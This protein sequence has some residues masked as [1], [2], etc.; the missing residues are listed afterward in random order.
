MS[1]VPRVHASSFITP[2][3]IIAA[4]NFHASIIHRTRVVILAQ[5]DS[6]IHSQTFPHHVQDKTRITPS[7]VHNKPEC[8]IVYS[9]TLYL[10]V[11]SLDAVVARVPTPS[12]DVTPRRP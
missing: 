3:T 11:F 12:A 8:P 1:D 2:I 10:R 6:L 4:F 9:T 7:R 5:K